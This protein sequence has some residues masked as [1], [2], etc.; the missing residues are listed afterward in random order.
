MGKDELHTYDLFKLVPEEAR[1]FW[2]KEPDEG[3]VTMHEFGLEIVVASGGIHGVP[4]NG[5]K[6]FTNVIFLD[7]ASL[8]PNII[9]V[10]NALGEYTDKFWAIVEERLAAKRKGDKVKA[11]ALKLIINSVYGL[12]KNKHSKLFNPKASL[13]VCVFGQIALYDLSRRLHEAGCTLVNL[14]TDGIGFTTNPH[15]PDCYKSIWKEWEKDFD[16]VLEE[17]M[18][19]RLIQKDVNN[20]LGVHA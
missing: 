2:C 10:L 11:D 20:Y 9:R 16:L 6:E 3:S 15:D 5:R 18:F 19:P 7:V 4:D 14:N 17:E 1:D 13:S 8:Y 12:L